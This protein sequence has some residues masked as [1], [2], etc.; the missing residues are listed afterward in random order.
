MSAVAV[1][2]VA[3]TAIGGVG[4]S[5]AAL[6]VGV[7]NNLGVAGPAGS[8]FPDGHTTQALDAVI[9][10]LQHVQA[11]TS[12]P[13]ATTAHPAAATSAPAKPAATHSA[14]AQAAQ[15]R[16]ASAKARPARHA[17]PAAA[18]PKPYL[19]YDSVLPAAIPAG[20]RVATYANGGYAVSP[21]EVAGRGPVLWIDTN[22]S[23]PQASALDVEPGDATPAGAAAWAKARLTADP[24]A[25]AIVYTMISEWQSV[26]DNVATLPS[27]MRARVRY[28]I[29]DPTG[30]PHV[31]AGA[32]ATQWYWG[33]NYDISTANPGFQ[34]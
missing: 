22:G 9:G 30:V 8:T 4:A 20:Q 10:T 15:A 5:A 7:I 6:S 32:D 28:W 31:L 33:T 17:K 29:A 13:A 18:P 12:T 27:W 14:T 1:T 19:F 26:K 11:A 25:V 2:A 3:A 34:A 21:S 24:K 16:A 23:D